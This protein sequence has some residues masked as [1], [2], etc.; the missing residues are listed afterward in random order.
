MTAI[1]ETPMLHN[2]DA[3]YTPQ[4]VKLARALA[5]R[6][7]PASTSAAIPCRLLT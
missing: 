7:N 1:S 2:I 4:Y 6:S 5:T 3:D